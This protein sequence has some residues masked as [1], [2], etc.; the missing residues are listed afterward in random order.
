MPEPDESKKTASENQMQES[1]VF[2]REN[3]NVKTFCKKTH[4]LI[5][6]VEKKRL[7]NKK[8]FGDN[9]RRNGNNKYS[10]NTE[11]RNT[12]DNRLFAILSQNIDFTSQ[13]CAAEFNEK[14]HTDISENTV[15]KI[16][17]INNFFK[18]SERRELF[19]WAV[20]TVA[21]FE[22]ALNDAEQS[23]CKVYISGFRGCGNFKHRIFCAALFA[24]HPELIDDE[25]K[26]IFENFNDDYARDISSGMINIL[27][28]ICDLPATESAYDRSL[29]INAEKL[30]KEKTEI[31]QNSYKRT[32]D[33]YDTLKS[34]FE[35]KLQERLQEERREFFAALNKKGILDGVTLAMDAVKKLQAQ[36]SGSQSEE[37]GA[38]L[39]F[40]R[41]IARFFAEN[42]IAPIM[43]DASGKVRNV[44]GGE[45]KSLNATF[46]G[47]SEDS[48]FTDSDD[49]KLVKVIS[50]GW[51]Y[52][53]RENIFSYPKLQEIV[54]EDEDFSEQNDLD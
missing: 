30:A 27:R 15:A 1:I 7:F 40:V 52:K 34:D 36:K 42:G 54:K 33:E 23:K 13:E 8:K 3:P 5:H 28:E 29:R 45:V 14:Y 11:S 38:L 26:K 31:I 4:D 17:R 51:F 24:K 44:T 39:A 53:S 25:D 9:R 41:N 6:S 21:K 12:E 50:P 49:I 48:H 43:K 16:F 18:D 37:V 10:Q 19:N 22:E 46:I 20:N 2:D 47:T 32:E 35:D